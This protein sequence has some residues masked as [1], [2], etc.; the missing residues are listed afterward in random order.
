M[1]QEM[2]VIHCHFAPF[3]TS[4]CH[5]QNRCYNINPRSDFRVK[6]I[7]NVCSRIEE[8][9]DTNLSAHTSGVDNLIFFA[10]AIACRSTVS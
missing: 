6:W 9:Y 10:G 3:G 7:D 2:I 1:P 8:V 4:I 5:L